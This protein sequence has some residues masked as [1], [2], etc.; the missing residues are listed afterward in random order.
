M[1][2]EVALDITRQLPRQLEATTRDIRRRLGGSTAPQVNLRPG[3]LFAT[4][5]R[6]REDGTPIA[7]GATLIYQ[8]TDQTTG[9]NVILKMTNQTEYFP[10]YDNEIDV[11]RQNISPVFPAL[12][13]YGQLQDSFGR[14]TEF[15]AMEE[16]E[17]IELRALLRGDPIPLSQAIETT[18]MVLFGLR[19][20]HTAG[21]IH[22]DLKPSNIMIA[23]NGETRLLDFGITCK[24]GHRDAEAVVGTPS[25]ISPEQVR[26]EPVGPGS[27]FYSLG[28]VLYEMMAGY[29]PMR[30]P[31]NDPL[32][33]AN[34]IGHNPVPALPREAV[35]RGLSAEAVRD[36]GTKIDSVHQRLRAIN[37][38]MT[39]LN[40]SERYQGAS[41]I[42]DQLHRLLP[43]IKELEQYGWV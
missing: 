22:R 5:Y 7:I 29:N 16:I 2:Y 8:A 15:I 20:L 40:I 18:M 24:N 4:R 39:E 6:I 25:Y 3:E 21:F 30:T 35:T 26:N 41:A 37:A 13:E 31:D 28:L 1:S 32:T 23:G 14:K 36:L 10:L 42:I 12:V 33:V 43:D 17:G 19:S 34:N 27:D 9:Q 38:R 11:L